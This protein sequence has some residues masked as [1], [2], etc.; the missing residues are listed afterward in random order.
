MKGLYQKNHICRDFCISRNS[1]GTDIT[2]TTTTTH[3][4]F[5]NSNMTLIIIH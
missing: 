4:I 5:E 1:R 2:T 3:I